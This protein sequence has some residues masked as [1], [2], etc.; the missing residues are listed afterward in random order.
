MRLQRQVVNSGTTWG[1]SPWWRKMVLHELVVTPSLF[2]VHPLERYGIFPVWAPLVDI[3]DTIFK[4]I[5]LVDNRCTTCWR[6]LV[7]ICLTLWWVNVLLVYTLYASRTICLSMYNER[8]VRLSPLEG[9]RACPDSKP[10]CLSCC[11]WLLAVSHHWGPA[12]MAVW[13]K[14]LPLTAS[15]VSPLRACPDTCV[16]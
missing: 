4:D 10:C 6:T 11:H 15:S 7:V 13:S 1:C 12:L 14:L 9:F 8:R 5:S 3:W 2:L 16:V